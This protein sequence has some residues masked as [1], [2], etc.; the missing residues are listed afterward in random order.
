MNCLVTG[1]T[2]FV[3]TSLVRHLVARGDRVTVVSRTGKAGPGGGMDGV[4]MHACDVADA[5]AIRNLVLAIQ[6]EAVF[7][8]AARTFVP[9]AQ[10]DALGFVE[11]NLLGTVHLLAAVRDHAAGCRV[12]MVS[13]AGVYG[14]SG[15]DGRPLSEE[16]PLHPLDPYAASKAAAEAWALQEHASSGL[17]VICVRPFGQIGP[18]QSERFA[19]AS[20]ARQLGRIRIGEQEAV[21]EVGNLDAIR[22]F[23]DVEDVVAGHVRALERGVPGRVYNLCSGQGHTIR[24]MLALLVAISGVKATVRQ[25]AGRLRPADVPALVGDPTRARQDLSWETKVTLEDSAGRLLDRWG[26]RGTATVGRG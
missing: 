1:G 3:G 22:E 20:F 19:A 7:H 9:D 24:E 14:A 15:R 18:W 6:P 16:T 26:A 2:G 23:N 12:L 5:E 13:S 4:E 10:K 25:Q 8:L 11:A 21:I 17:A